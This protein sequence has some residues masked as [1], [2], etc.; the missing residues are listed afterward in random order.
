MTE[1]KKEYRYIVTYTDGIG[2]WFD[3]PAG[4]FWEGSNVYDYDKAEFL[5]DDEL[6]SETL[7]RE[8]ECDSALSEALLHAR[9]PK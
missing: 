3:S 4:I 1:S 9:K 6:D 7:R 5:N 8:A 2:W